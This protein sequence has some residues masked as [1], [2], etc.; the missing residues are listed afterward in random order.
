MSNVPGELDEP[1][2]V[3]EACVT[4]E[5]NVPG[6]AGE[7]GEPGVLYVQG[8]FIQ[9]CQVCGVS[10]V[11][12]KF[13]QV[14]WVCCMSCMCPGCAGEL[15]PGWMHPGEPD[16]FIWVN[17]FRQRGRKSP[18]GG[19]FG[20]PTPCSRQNI[21]TFV[22]ALPFGFRPEFAPSRKTADCT[23]DLSFHVTTQDC[24]YA[25]TAHK[26]LVNNFILQ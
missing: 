13:I 5:L 11:P 7:V 14:C 17:S 9:V 26:W 6:E 15:G 8:E 2:E 25:T 23:Q 19:Y 10:C 22:D 4:G 20:A 21:E 16:G 18:P 3:G 24:G 1:V 12:G